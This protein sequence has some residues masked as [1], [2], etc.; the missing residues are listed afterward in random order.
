M[1]ARNII[2]IA[3][4]L[5][6]ALGTAYFV[7]NW[8]ANQRPVVVE[9]IQ[10][11]PTAPAAEILVAAR[12]LP[13]GSLLRPGD[14]D[15]QAWPEDG[16]SPAYVARSPAEPGE[17]DPMAHFEGAVVRHGITAG[18]PITENRVV[19]P[20]DRGFMAAILSPGMRAVSVPISATTGIAGF[21]F[22]GDRV[23][24][25]LIHA[26]ERGDAASDRILRASETVLTNVRV[27]A[28]DQRVADQG[29]PVVAKTATLEVTPKQAETITMLTEM[30][31]L[32]LSLRSLAWEGA[33][34]AD[35]A[36]VRSVGG[37][38]PSIAQSG[39]S[40]TLDNEVSALLNPPR[41]S[42]TVR[43]REVKVVRGAAAEAL[44]FATPRE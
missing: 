24:V 11:T 12:T 16:V 14:L 44:S 39:Q 23:D 42:S 9:Q 5:I 40:Y 31:R 38:E 29:N 4:A 19:R 25:I 32:T 21:V 36:D 10:T 27:L 35:A 17:A 41:T 8:S 13:A 20:G 34:L 43:I 3:F 7:K 1:R 37:F 30:G 6:A 28:V 2:L 33:V 18:E 15:W 22:P 26:I